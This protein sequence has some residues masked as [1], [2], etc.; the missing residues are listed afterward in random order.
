MPSFA[1]FIEDNALDCFYKKTFGLECMGCGFQRSLIHLFRGEWMDSI[2]MFPA[3]LPTL[4]LLI[5]TIIHIIFKIR[6]GHKVI[7]GLFILTVS[8]MLGN[9]IYKQYVFWT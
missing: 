3:L 7:L 8:L 2:V 1:D 9:F 6:N 4:A 5:F